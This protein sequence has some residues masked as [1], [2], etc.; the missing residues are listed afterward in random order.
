M[1]TSKCVIFQGKYMK[2]DSE[3]EFTKSIFEREINGKSRKF[4]VQ[5]LPDDQ[6]EKAISYF[7]RYFMRDEPL[8]KSLSKY[9]AISHMYF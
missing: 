3:V 2:M 4:W 7:S 9:T 8:S 6:K 5:L 1:S